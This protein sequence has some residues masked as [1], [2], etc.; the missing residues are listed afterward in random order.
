MAVQM[1]PSYIQSFHIFHLTQS[2]D[3]PVA[4]PSKN[5][6]KFHRLQSVI[7]PK[8]YH[9]PHYPLHNLPDLF[10]VGV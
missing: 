6:T 8:L 3:H 9:S 7:N 4:H 5:L 10:Y 1:P 2:Q